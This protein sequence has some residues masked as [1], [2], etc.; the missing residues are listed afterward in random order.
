MATCTSVV[1]LN[2]DVRMQRQIHLKSLSLSGHVTPS[3]RYFLLQLTHPL[4]SLIVKNPSP[5]LFVRL[6]HWILGRNLWYWRDAGIN[7]EMWLAGWCSIPIGAIT[8]LAIGLVWS[9]RANGKVRKALV[10]RH[11]LQ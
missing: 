9:R 1:A 5:F 10:A 2:A 7:G 6:M 11:L 8:G 3:H 4:R